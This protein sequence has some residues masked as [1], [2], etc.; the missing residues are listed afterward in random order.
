MASNL[1]R[2]IITFE[3]FKEELDNGVKANMKTV[4]EHLSAEDAPMAFDRDGLIRYIKQRMPQDEYPV[5]P[6][7]VN[8]PAGLG[9]YFYKL[10]R[11]LRDQIFSYL[12]VSGHPNFMR[13]SKA[14]E[15]EGETW[16]AKEG[17][18]RINLRLFCSI[19]CQRP[20][21]KIAATIQN[22]DIKIDAC[23]LPIARNAYPNRYS[24]LKILDLLTDPTH[25][26]KTCNVS[27]EWYGARDGCMYIVEVGHEVIDRLQRLR[28]FEK[29]VLR[30]W[31]R[32]TDSP[33]ILIP[34]V[35]RL[36]A[37]VPGM[38]ID[39][40]WSFGHM[41]DR[42]APYLGKADMTSDK[43]GW[44]MVFYPRKAQEGAA[45]VGSSGSLKG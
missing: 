8:I 4:E 1:S 17:I 7:P 6:K 34:S 28:G 21:W 44:G 31:D 38:V 12:L 30:V 43:E 13:C 36:R 39:T 10:P 26:R 32:W 19:N 37:P 24:G 14:M 40:Y 20:S 11:E 33:S 2:K 42:L 23:M 27:I 35:D 3:A 29:V 22:I 41:Q 25:H 18:Y 15:Q 45:Q 9:P 16:V 5:Q